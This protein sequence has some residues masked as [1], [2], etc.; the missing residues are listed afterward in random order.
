VFIVP[1]KFLSC[2][3][4]VTKSNKKRYG[5]QKYNPYAVCRVSTGFFGSTYDKKKKR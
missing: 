4:A 1:E 2:V 3:R 5:K